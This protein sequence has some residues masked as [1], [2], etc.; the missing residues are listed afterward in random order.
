M[1]SNILH[2]WTF[3]IFVFWI[4]YMIYLV[5]G[6][7]ACPSWYGFESGSTRSRKRPRI[8]GINFERLV[9]VR[10]GEA[11]NAKWTFKRNNEK[12]KKLNSKDKKKCS[13]PGAGKRIKE[14]STQGPQNERY[15]EKKKKKKKKTQ[16]LRPATTLGWVTSLEEKTP[17]G[18]V[19]NP[20]RGQWSGKWIYM[21]N[22]LN[23][24]LNWVEL[25]IIL[26]HRKIVLVD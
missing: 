22:Y 4:C 15:N 8:M 5:P 3:Y 17:A 21:K 7:S 19:S 16:L 6:A 26:T 12:K 14:L 10:E 9:L 23:L 11:G 2:I 24:T 18:L 25:I 20:A 1:Y 13:T